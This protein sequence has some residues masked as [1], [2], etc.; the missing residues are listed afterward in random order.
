MKIYI[1]TDFIRIITFNFKIRRKF[2]PH[3]KTNNIFYI[4]IN[5]IKTIKTFP[6][7]FLLDTHR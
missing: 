4:P 2:I 6:T 5:A 7:I 1:C 3:M